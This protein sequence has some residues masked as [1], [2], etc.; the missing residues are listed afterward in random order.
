[1]LQHRREMEEML[2]YI[3]QL[4]QRIVELERQK[5]T[6]PIIEQPTKQKRR[7]IISFFL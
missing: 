1:M 7:G 2:Q 4:E 6:E 3:Q 5:Q